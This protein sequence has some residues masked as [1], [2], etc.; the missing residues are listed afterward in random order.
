MANENADSRSNGTPIFINEVAIDRIQAAFETQNQGPLIYSGSLNQQNLYHQT[1]IVASKP[2]CLLSH[3]RRVFLS[4][5]CK[6]RA[7]VIGAFMDL[8]LILRGRGGDLFE[9]LLKLASTI[10][11]S[12]LKDGLGRAFQGDDMQQMMRLPLDYSVLVNGRGGSIFQL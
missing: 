5:H 11:G 4:I 6:N 12:R 9:R 8:F 7:A 1:R 10:L 2:H 3:V